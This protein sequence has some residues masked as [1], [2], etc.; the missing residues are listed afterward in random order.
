[1]YSRSPRA[2]IRP[3]LPRPTFAAVLRLPVV[4]PIAI[5]MISGQLPQLPGQFAQLGWLPEIQ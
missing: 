4:P 1:M 2:L 3:Q 5:G